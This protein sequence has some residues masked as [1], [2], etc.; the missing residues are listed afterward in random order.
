MRAACVARRRPAELRSWGCVRLVL[1]Y[2]GGIYSLPDGQRRRSS[3]GRILR[4]KRSQR[5]IQRQ[6]T[7]PHQ[8]SQSLA[9]L[10][11]QIPAWASGAVPTPDYQPYIPTPPLAT[12]N[13]HTQPKVHIQRL[14]VHLTCISPLSQE[15]LI[16]TRLQAAIYMCRNARCGRHDQYVSRSGSVRKGNSGIEPFKEG[17]RA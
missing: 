10:T 2:H 14:S 6:Y 9:R 12:S 5:A 11:I 7:M 16:F 13:Q 4:P 1:E 15:R 3:R 17:L 8:Q